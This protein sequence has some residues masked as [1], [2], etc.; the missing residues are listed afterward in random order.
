MKKMI[1]V[2]IVGLLGII[3]G[4][5]YRKERNI[6]E[7]IPFLVGNW[8]YNEDGSFIF[9]NDNSFVQYKDSNL[10]NNY[11][12]GK[13]E[14]SYGMKINDSFIYYDKAYYYYDLILRFDYCYINSEYRYNYDSEEFALAIS[15]NDEND[16]FLLDSKGNILILKGAVN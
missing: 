8:L 11:C 14:Y 7:N 9:N 15:K 2:I 12:I 4:N 13:Y 1:A 10:D 3:I 6:Y 16:L 5:S